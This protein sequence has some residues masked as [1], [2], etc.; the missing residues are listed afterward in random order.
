MLEHRR[1]VLDG[2]TV[3]SAECVADSGLFVAAQCD[4][5]VGY[6]KKRNEDRA[7]ICPAD[8]VFAVID[9]MGGRGDGDSAAQAIAEE[10]G[11]TPKDI[12]AAIARARERIADFAPGAAACIMVSSF[13]PKNEYGERELTT[14]QAGDVKQLIIHR[15]H[16]MD[17]LRRRKRIE[18]S[19]D[20]NL[21]DQLRQA[22]ILS[23]REAA[24]DPRRNQVTNFVSAERYEPTGGKS[25][26][27][28]GDRVLLYSDG[29]GNNQTSK[30]VIALNVRQSLSELLSAVWKASG[31]QMRKAQEL[32]QRGMDPVGCQCD[33]RAFIGIDVT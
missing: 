26:V 25:V 32:E 1:I 10:I 7:L 3:S 19:A 17:V 15:R 27:G 22:G 9:G 13:G 11:E 23:A 20:E 18:E 28:P 16:F 4:E 8:D 30:Q 29:I 31:E 6:R 5:G 2:V 21:V 14:V 12:C 24:K 33:N